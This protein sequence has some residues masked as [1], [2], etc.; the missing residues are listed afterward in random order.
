LD[1][2]AA[3]LRRRF[4]QATALPR[5]EASVH[6]AALTSAGRVCDTAIR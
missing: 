1:G 2:L 5:A 3:V 4:G 6:G